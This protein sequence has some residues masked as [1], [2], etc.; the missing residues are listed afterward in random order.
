MSFISIYYLMMAILSVAVLH[1]LSTDKFNYPI[2]I[3]ISFCTALF[4]FIFAAIRVGG[5]DFLTYSDNFYS[6]NP[7]I[8]DRGFIFLMK[9]FREMGLTINHLLLTINLIVFYSIIRT[10]KLFIVPLTIVFFIYLSHFFLVRDLAQFRS[11]LAISLF[12]LS[13]HRSFAVALLL[14]IFATT[15]HL[16]V[17]PLLLAFFL[18]KHFEKVIFSNFRLFLFIGFLSALFTGQIINQI[19]EFLSIVDT[20]VL[21]YAGE[22]SSF[23]PRLKSQYFAFFLFTAVILYSIFLQGLHNIRYLHKIGIIVSLFG[24]KF[25]VAFGSVPVLGPRIFNVLLSFY[26]YILA[27]TVTPFL[28]QT[29]PFKLK[30]G[31]RALICAA[32]LGCLLLRPSSFDLL[33]KIE[34]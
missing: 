29:A 7:D 4:L 16:S 11:S 22:D 13:L 3:H 30:R 21:T 34:L 2:D 24:L 27:G 18:A 17:L 6:L 10:S 20:R 12:F 32:L 26:P 25:W 9:L 5:P 15:I 1:R 28:V 33:A 31:A 14:N 19:L 8:P 23:D